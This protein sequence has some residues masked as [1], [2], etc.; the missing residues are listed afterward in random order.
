[1]NKL[2]WAKYLF[3][4]WIVAISISI[5]AKYIISEPLLLIPISIGIYWISVKSF[6]KIKGYQ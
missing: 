1:M 6:A 5:I 3:S 2:S 4:I